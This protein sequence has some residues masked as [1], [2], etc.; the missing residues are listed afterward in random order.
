[1][2]SALF[3]LFRTK[4][5]ISNSKRTLLWYTIDGSPLFLLDPEA[6]PMAICLLP[7]QPPQA[8]SVRRTLR[9]RLPMKHRF[10]LHMVLATVVVLCGCSQQQTSE[11]SEQ[12]ASTAGAIEIP[13]EKFVLDNGLTL[14]VHEDHKAPVVA[15]NVWYHV[16]SNNEKP[17]KT[18]F[19]HLFEHLMFNGSENFNDDYIQVPFEPSRR[20][21]DEWHHQ[22]RGPHQLLPGRTQN[23][24]RHGSVDGV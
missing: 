16:G 9:R 21:G 17:G 22:L 19:A 1:M 2:K 8:A 15:V 7:R 23:G 6:G 4:A 18:G 12:T 3:I 14:I 11:S 24:A 5:R 13:F 20:H 10:L